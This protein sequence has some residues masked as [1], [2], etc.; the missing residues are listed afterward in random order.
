MCVLRAEAHWSSGTRLC[1]ASLTEVLRELLGESLMKLFQV[2]EHNLE[3]I[4]WW[5]DG[6]PV[7]KG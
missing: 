2:F 3:F 1:G 6:H 5:Q 7:R 4:S